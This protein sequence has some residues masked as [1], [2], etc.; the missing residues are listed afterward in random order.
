MAYS[1]QFNNVFEA[2]NVLLILFYI[3]IAEIQLPKIDIQL[4]SRTRVRY[5]EN[6]VTAS[7]IVFLVSAP[8]FTKYTYIE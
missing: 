4:L 5:L 6:R 7:L 3:L 2:V 1:A 8:S